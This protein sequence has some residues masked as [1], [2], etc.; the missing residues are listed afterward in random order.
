MEALRRHL[1]PCGFSALL[2]GIDRAAAILSGAPL[3]EIKD[4]SL[5][6]R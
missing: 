4:A 6:A 3:A 2:T 1:A 5:D